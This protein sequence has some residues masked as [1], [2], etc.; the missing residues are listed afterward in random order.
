MQRPHPPLCIGGGGEKRTLRTTARFAQHWNVPGGGVDVFRHKR[1]VLHA[2]CADIGRDPFE[3]E[4]S[5]HLRWSAERPLGD[6]VDEAAAF[7]DAGMDLGV[8]ALAPPHDPR[9]LG[10]LAEALEP[11][12]RS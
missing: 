2:H 5:T 12:S 3:I 10:P 8:V 1:D 7:A 4:T 9:V 11:L 6:L